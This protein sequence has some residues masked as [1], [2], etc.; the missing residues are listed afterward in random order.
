M[1]EISNYLK[2]SM[3]DEEWQAFCLSIHLLCEDLFANEHLA[4]DVAR[5]VCAHESWRWQ[6]KP[7]FPRYEITDKA[8]VYI[9]MPSRY[10]KWASEYNRED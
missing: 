1:T 3:N 7:E 2:L 8:K 6:N 9:K 10:N 5:I 4:E